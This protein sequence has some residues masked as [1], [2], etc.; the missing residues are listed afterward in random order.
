MFSEY[1]KKNILKCFTK[2]LKEANGRGPRNVYIKYL[3]DEVHVVMY[4]VVSDFEKYLIKNFGNEAIEILTDFY[5]RDC[6]N[7]EN[8]F[9]ECFTCGKKLK[10]YELISDFTNDYFEYK[11]KI[12]N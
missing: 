11:M 1:E 10:F 8:F 9:L 5:Q 2:L 7:A 6:L 4:G 3:E 12:Y